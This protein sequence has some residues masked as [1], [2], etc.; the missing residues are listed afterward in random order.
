MDM[1]DKGHKRGAMT[2]MTIKRGNKEGNGYIWS[3]IMKV[4]DSMTEMSR[5]HTYLYRRQP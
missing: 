4:C 2:H 5:K 3:N 1:V